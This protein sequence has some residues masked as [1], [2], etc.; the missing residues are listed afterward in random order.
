MSIRITN[1]QLQKKINNAVK[2]IPKE[3]GISNAEILIG[4]A[5]EHY[6]AALKKN[7]IIR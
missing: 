5:V 2:K 6:I 3:L 1:Q 7:R 4:N